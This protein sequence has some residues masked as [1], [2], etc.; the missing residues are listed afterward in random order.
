MKNSAERIVSREGLNAAQAFFER[1]GTI[2][3]EI[4]QQNDFGKDGYLDFGEGDRIF[5]NDDRDLD[6]DLSCMG[7]SSFLC[8]L[9]SPFCVG[10][11]HFIEL[12]QRGFV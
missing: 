3:Q 8:L 7:C 2:F 11:M 1:H 5:P 9:V 12:S 6:S 4:P 10:D